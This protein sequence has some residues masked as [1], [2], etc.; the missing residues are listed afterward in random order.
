MESRHVRRTL[1]GILDG[2]PVS[3]PRVISEA[4]TAKRLWSVNNTDVVV[5]L[6]SK[7]SVSGAKTALR[8]LCEA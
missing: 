4:D 7:S 8:A 5:R 2:T 3:P 6:S 1:D